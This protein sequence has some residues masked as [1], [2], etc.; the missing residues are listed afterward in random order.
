MQRKELNPAWCHFLGYGNG[1]DLANLESMLDSGVRIAGLF[2]EFPSNPL[3][4]CHDMEK[5][6]ES[7]KNV[8]VNSR[9]EHENLDAELEESNIHKIY[10]KQLARR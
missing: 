4:R 2:T 8:A 5:L 3:L 6:S 10:I 7:S 9:S 1:G